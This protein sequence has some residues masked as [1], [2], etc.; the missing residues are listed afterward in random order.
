MIIA[1]WN[2]ERLKHGKDI[3]VIMQVSISLLILLP[4]KTVLA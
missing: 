1:T 4:R 2:V 3:K